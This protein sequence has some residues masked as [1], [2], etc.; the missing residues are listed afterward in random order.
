[1]QTFASIVV[2]PV[3]TRCGLQYGLQ[4]SKAR[5]GSQ[6][7]DSR[8]AEDLGPRRAARACRLR[9][10]F[11]VING[12]F[13]LFRSTSDTPQSNRPQKPAVHWLCRFRQRRPYRRF[14]A[15][16][17]PLLRHSTLLRWFVSAA[18]R[19]LTSYQSRPSKAGKRLTVHVDGGLIDLEA[20]LA[21]KRRMAN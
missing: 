9:P 3:S 21:S 5:N 11:S 19:G 20:L 15:Q 18:A 17:C 7:F 12:L 1:M 13:S 10:P 14:A 8:N 2:P 4:W 6:C 16:A